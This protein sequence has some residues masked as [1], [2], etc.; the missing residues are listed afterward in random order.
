MI[1]SKG[2][3][4]EKERVPNIFVCLM[5]SAL[6]TSTSRI[7]PFMCLRESKALN[8]SRSFTSS[9]YSTINSL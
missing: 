6:T 1:S 8:N 3:R 5:P 2:Q 7:P 9:F 4:R